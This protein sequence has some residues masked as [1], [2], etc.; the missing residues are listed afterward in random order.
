MVHL[1]GEAPDGADVQAGGPV[2][3]HEHAEPA[4]P[5]RREVGAGQ[6]QAVVG[7][8]GVAAPDLVPVDHP[9]V[10]VALGAGLEPEQVGPGVGLAEPLPE[11]GLAAGDQRQ[12]LAAQALRAVARIDSAVWS[13]P[14]RGPNGA[15]PPPAPRA[16]SAGSPWDAPGRPTPGASTWR[17]IR[18]RPEPGGTPA[19]RLRTRSPHPSRPGGTGQRVLAE[20]PLHL[21]RERSLLRSA[22][23]LH[24]T[25]A[26]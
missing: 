24:L 17:A 16:G 12:Q 23:E 26:A 8:A 11:R 1:P 18:A 14:A 15:P 6:D 2:V 7:D 9:A 21:R 3:H 4:G 20:E 25:W 22:P 19:R 10:P 5:A 13:Q